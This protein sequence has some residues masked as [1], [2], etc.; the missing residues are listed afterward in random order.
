MSNWKDK[1]NL[2]SRQATTRT[3]GG[4]EWRFHPVSV[5]TMFQMRQTVIPIVD[6]L[7]VLFARNNTDVKQSIEAIRSVS[8]GTIERTDIEG[9]DVTLAQFRAKQK[10]EALEKAVNCIL[11]EESKLAIGKMLVDSLRDDFPTR[12]TPETE[13]KA[14][15]DALDLAAFVE[16][17]MGFCA[18]NAEVF[19]PLGRKAVEAA[20]QKVRKAIEEQQAEGGEDRAPSEG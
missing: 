1:I 5:S 6:A 7:S 16:M 10:R 14:F 19:G 17:L 9:I 4:Q 13:I 18:A 11:A 8:E 20:Q 2:F 12:P 15:V 3:I